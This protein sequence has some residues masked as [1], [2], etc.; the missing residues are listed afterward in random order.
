MPCTT[1]RVFLSTRTLNASYSLRIQ[2]CLLGMTAQ[3]STAPTRGSN[4]SP[5][6]SSLT[7]DFTDRSI[8]LKLVAIFRHVHLP[9]EALGDVVAHG[10]GGFRLAVRVENATR[11]G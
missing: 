6:Q 2:F 1:R 8:K 4:N 7:F 11:R 9:A 10:V 3:Y 5:N